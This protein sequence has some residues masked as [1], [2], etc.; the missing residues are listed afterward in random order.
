[1][2]I[3]TANEIFT[4]C[5]YERMQAV[6]PGV[7]EMELFEF[8]YALDN[9]VPAEGWASLVPWEKTEIE[10]IV[11]DS[12]FYHG[13]QLRPTEGNK[14]VM[15]AQVRLLTQTLFAGLVQRVYEVEWIKRHFTFDI[16]GFYFLHRTQY[17]TED[18]I[19]HMGGSPYR[20]FEPKQKQ[21]ETAQSVGYQDFKAANVEVDRCFID[22]VFKLAEIM[23][24]P[25]LVAI[26]GQTAAGKTEIVQRLT[27]RF[28]ASNKMV[29]SLEM[30]HFLLDRDYREARG[31]DSLG[32]EALHYDLFKTCLRDILQG[33]QVRI[34]RYDFIAATSSHSLD[35]QL[36]PGCQPLVVEP[37][38]IIFMEGNF[39][40]LHPEIAALVGIKVMY[41]T[42]DAMRMKRKW[43]RDMDYRKKYDLM[44]FL[45]RY[46]REQF[47]MAERVY[48]P[49]MAVCDIIVDTSAAT[50]WVTSG[51][52]QLIEKK[53]G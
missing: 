5:L 43:K 2:E 35:G 44:Y 26:A 36:K 15:D 27:S 52:Q 9:L 20:Q 34:P 8:A 37:A 46:F 23:G 7:V 51:M 13:I 47:I 42:D 19:R 14:S 38:D 49:Q 40:F 1:M 48:R 11:N 24:S 39:P 22:L 10:R 30:D 12:A 45:N 41:L 33:R 3:S 50:L 31:I 6:N 53:N 17:Y 16:R 28:V 18:T 25:I 32:M 4:R 21:F 29:T